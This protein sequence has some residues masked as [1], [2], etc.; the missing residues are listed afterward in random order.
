MRHNREIPLDI[1]QQNDTYNSEWVSKCR[2]IGANY[3]PSEELDVNATRALDANPFMVVWLRNI[4]R[5]FS[6]LPKSLDLSGYI[7]IDVGC[8][9]GISTSYIH[10]NYSLKNVI[11]F[12]FSPK[13][14][15]NALNNKKILYGNGDD[16]NSLNFECADASTYLIPNEKIILFLFNPFGWK[17]MKSFIENNTAALSKNDSLML[18]ANDVYINEISD[19]AKVIARDE[20]FNL[21]IVA[22]GSS[23]DE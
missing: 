6:L 15:N 19:Y 10:K 18:Y 1:R 7:L 16:G 21:S 12:D 9:S 14:V 20:F 5:L 13:L 22:F 17:T 11:G 2:L 3:V 4:D 8:G 23:G